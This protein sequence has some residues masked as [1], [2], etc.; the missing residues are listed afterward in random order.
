MQRTGNNKYVVHVMKNKSFSLLF[1][2]ALTI[3]LYHLNIPFMNSN[4][5][6]ANA[7]EPPLVAI[8]FFPTPVFSQTDT[9][10]NR[11]KLVEAIKLMD[12]GTRCQH[13]NPEKTCK[14][15]TQTTILYNYELAYAFFHQKG[16]PSGN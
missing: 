13:H 14:S 10:P 5:Y 16:L 2:K 15:W 11:A 3:K 4:A 6:S 9:D 8:L 12:K 7:F 1:F